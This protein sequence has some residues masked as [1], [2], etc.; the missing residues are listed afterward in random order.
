M[1]SLL[2]EHAIKA[3]VFRKYEYLEF[4]MCSEG[5]G[6]GDHEYKIIETAKRDNITPILST[7]SLNLFPPFLLDLLDLG[8]SPTRPAPH[9]AIS[10]I[11]QENQTFIIDHM[12]NSPS[13]NLWLSQFE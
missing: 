1:M 11:N 4:P 6:R 10:L 2:I 12:T 3:A 7:Y 9:I 5:R 8:Y 13:I